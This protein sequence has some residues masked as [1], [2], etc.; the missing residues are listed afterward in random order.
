MADIAQKRKSRCGHN[1]RGGVVTQRGFG[2]P[3]PLLKRQS[4]CPLSY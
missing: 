4:L 3:D 2:T 1:V